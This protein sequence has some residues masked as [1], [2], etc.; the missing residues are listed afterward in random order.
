MNI[1]I[2]RLPDRPH[3][4]LERIRASINNPSLMGE[5]GTEVRFARIQWCMILWR[6]LTLIQIPVLIAVSADRFVS[7]GYAA[8]FFSVALAY[9]LIYSWLVTRTGIA[10]NR[11]FRLTDLLIGAVMLLVAHEATLV[12]VMAFYTYACLVNRPILVMRET[13][14]AVCGMSLVFLTASEMT[15]NPFYSMSLRVSEFMLYYFWGLAILFFSRLLSRSSALE[16][17]A[18]LEKQRQGY[19]RRL[20]DDLG[21]TLCG[22]HYRIQ[23]LKLSGGDELR[24]ALIFLHRGYERANDVLA[25]LL[26][27]IDE[28]AEED[29]REALT[30]TAQEAMDEF[31][32]EVGITLPGKEIKVSPAIKREIRSIVREAIANSAKHAGNGKTHIDVTGSR[33]R[34]TVSV[35]DSGAGFDTS[36]LESKQDGG[37]LGIKNMQERAAMIDGLFSLTSSPGAG[38]T[39]TLSIGEQKTVGFIRRLTKTRSRHP[40]RV[41]S[42]LIYLKLIIA[43]LAMMQVALME[44]DLRNNPVSWMV[45]TTVMVDGALFFFFP[46]RLY[47]LLTRLPWLLIIEQIV[48]SVLIFAA[49]REDMPLFFD[50]VPSMGLVMSACFLGASGNAALAS[51]LSLGILLANLL[52]PATASMHGERM[53]EMVVN[54]SSN[55]LLAFIAGLAVEFIRN[56][57]G[58]QHQAIARALARQRERLT[59]DTH[60]KL[61]SR[62]HAVVLDV[63][64]LSE[65]LNDPG[66]T[67]EAIAGLEATSNELKIRLRTIM[68]S[69]DKPAEDYSV[70]T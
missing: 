17:D 7:T 35:V 11:Y 25:H 20:H 63:R 42:F 27:E 4:L 47:N 10:G 52:A 62:V 43:A 57:E 15:P 41:Y 49:W 32:M 18:H 6:L 13:I 48:F 22:L 24:Q 61:H 65:Q 37:S 67:T 3:G 29:L 26:D 34:L 44:P 46:S 40:D 14:L 12:Y 68:R 45:A 56:L 5:R 51:L 39:V 23:S 38:T 60:R 50:A 9:T 8:M 70:A 55:L 54:I 16:L 33:G 69:L 30:R 21:N 36:G 53:E 2:D 28:I 59:A 58:L 1:R 31:G 66:A 64:L 19:R